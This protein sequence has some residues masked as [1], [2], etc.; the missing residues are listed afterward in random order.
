MAADV[1]KTA[2][3]AVA[4]AHGQDRLVQELECLEVALPRHVVLVAHEL[5][6]LPEDDLFLELEELRITVD[7]ARKAEVVLGAEIGCGGARRR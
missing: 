2:H 4:A 3:A 5:P 1:V 7:P 6:G